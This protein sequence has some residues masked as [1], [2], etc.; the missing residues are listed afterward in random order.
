MCV[1]S[2]GVCVCCP[3]MCAVQQG[4]AVQGCPAQGGVLP[5][6]MSCPRGCIQIGVLSRNVCAVPG[7]G[8]CGDVIHD[9][10]GSDI[11]TPPSPHCEQNE[12]QT[13][14]KIL[15]CSKLRLQAVINVFLRLTQIL[16]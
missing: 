6:G 13:L 9:R 7:V 3:E 15:P 4:C 5:N 14:V 16:L 10:T 1:L 2:R 12:S 8:G 11:I